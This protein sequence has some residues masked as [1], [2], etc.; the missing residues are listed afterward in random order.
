MRIFLLVLVAF[1]LHSCTSEENVPPQITK[2]FYHLNPPHWLYGSW[3]SGLD[4]N[5]IILHISEHNIVDVQ[6]NGSYNIKDS[7]VINNWKTEES[8]ILSTKYILYIPNFGED[9]SYKMTF[10]YL[11]NTEFE[12]EQNLIIFSGNTT[13]TFDTTNIYTKK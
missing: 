13:T 12:L 3:S 10:N 8:F 7:C 5:Q 6:E 11:T 4:S 1:I 9:K 2:D